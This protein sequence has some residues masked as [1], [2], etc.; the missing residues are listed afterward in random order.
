MVLS[1]N[2]VN[3]CNWSLQLHKDTS[4]YSEHMAI[5]VFQ[6]LIH[7]VRLCLELLGDVPEKGACKLLLQGAVAHD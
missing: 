3:L 2:N 4:H 1:H 7:I 5:P 6:R